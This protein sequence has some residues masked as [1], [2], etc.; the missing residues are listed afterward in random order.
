[1]ISVIHNHV[2]FDG[3]LHRPVGAAGPA[4]LQA[5]VASQ[6]FARHHD[7]FAIDNGLPPSVLRARGSPV[8]VT[9]PQGRHI[10]R[11]HC[12]PLND[13]R[14]VAGAR[15]TILVEYDRSAAAHQEACHRYENAA[16]VSRELLRCRE[17][18]KDRMAKVPWHPGHDATV[19]SAAQLR[20]TC[21]ACCRIQP[22]N[23]SATFTGVADSLRA[24]C[25]SRRGRSFTKLQS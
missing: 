16:V 1:M 11:R 5:A 6:H 20:R 17:G 21:H 14:W 22:A 18:A 8:G 4:G 25:R 13:R 9:E 24:G 23:L 12:C 3:P 10:L 7:Y 2:T 19:S 15:E